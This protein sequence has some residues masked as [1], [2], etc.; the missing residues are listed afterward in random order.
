MTGSSVDLQLLS[1]FEAGLDPRRPE[2]GA[3]PANVL[4]YGETSTVLTMSGEEAP[5]RVY[6]RLPVFPG[7]PEAS[8]YE[9]LHRRYIRT[10]GERAGVRVAS[11][12]TAQVSDASHRYVVVYIVQE[13]VPVD[14]V[15]DMV[16]YRL[17]QSDVSRLVMAILGETAK[18]FDLNHIH[19]GALELGIDSEISNWALLGFDPD[20]GTLPDRI[21]LMYLHTSVPLMRRQ[22]VEQLD[23][24][25]FL[26]AAPAILLPLIRRMFLPELMTRF[27]DFRRVAIDLV[28][29]IHQTD[30]SELVPGIIDAVNWYFLA[31]RREHHFR[32]ITP[33]EVRRFHRWD[34]FIW[35]TYLILRRV[36]RRARFLR[37]QPYPYI[38]PNRRR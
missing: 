38:L 2:R 25:L 13:V 27:Y 33:E 18:V 19:Q 12:T 34:A 15:C 20:K 9:V 3:V 30:R 7:A 28:A 21:K 29:K 22:G 23:P 11:S 37:R 1:R 31:E 6:K 24:E 14:T 5:A 36:D 16:A 26:R 32:P 4:H 17:P 8:K 35:R 10:L